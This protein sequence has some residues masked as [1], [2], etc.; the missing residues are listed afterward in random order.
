MMGYTGIY[1]LLY[2]EL[3]FFFWLKDINCISINV[4]F[5]IRGWISL[6]KY[7][8]RFRACGCVCRFTGAYLYIFVYAFREL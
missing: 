4:L 2:E 8:Q 3:K 1:K 6:A 7:C 5:I